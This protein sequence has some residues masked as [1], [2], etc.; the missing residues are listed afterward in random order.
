VRIPSSKSLKA[1]RLLAILSTALLSATAAQAVTFSDGLTHTIDKGNSFPLEGMTI[2]DGPGATPTS[3]TMV[4]GG[5]IGTF[6]LDGVDVRGA[7]VL[8]IAGGEIGGFVVGFDQAAIELTGAGRVPGVTLRGS[9]TFLMDGG[10]NPNEF[11]VAVEALDDSSVTIAADAVIEGRFS[12]VARDRSEL[13]ALGGV[14]HSVIGTGSSAV[15]ICCVLSTGAV[16]GFGSTRM[17]VSGGVFSSDL[18]A[19]EDARMESS[20]GEF[21]GA[22]SATDS[23]SLTITGGSVAGGLQSSGEAE[24]TV[25]GG[26]LGGQVDALDSSRVSVLGTDFNYPPGDIPDIQGTLMGELRDGTSFEW[27]FERA[28]TASITLLL[29]EPQRWAQSVAALATLFALARS[30]KR[31]HYAGA[32]RYSR[33]TSPSICSH[34]LESIP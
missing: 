2:T 22:A 31:R 28:S 17:V 23:A 5:A 29:P 26:Q 21:D 3:V 10:L 4:D 15:D 11:F 9:S 7:S 20:G 16:A 13:H 33:G 12:F 34:P 18:S 30:P 27:S 24:I 1:G 19:F 32:C 8:T 25:S 6:A 14:I